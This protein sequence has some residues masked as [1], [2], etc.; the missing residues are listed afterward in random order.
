MPSTPDPQSELDILIRS[1][2]GVIVLDTADEARADALIRQA[3]SRL[4]L[5]M[6]RWTRHAGLERL[7]ASEPAREGTDIPLGA[8]RAVAS[9]AVEG[10]FVFPVLEPWLEEP[11]VASALRECALVLGQRRGAV[12]LQG[13]AVRLPPG[14]SRDAATLALPH[15]TQDEYRALLARLAADLQPKMELRPE[16]TSQLLQNLQGMTTTEARRILTRVMLE[17]G[18]LHAG[19]IDR[20]ARAKRESIMQESLLEY[21]TVDETLDDVAGLERLKAWLQKRQTLLREPERARSLGLPFPRGLLLLGV[22]GCGKS[23]SAKAIAR[24]WGL[25]LV[26]LDSAR[27]YNKYV[28]ETERNLHR[29]I[30]AAEQAAPVVLWIDEIE[31]A[32]ATDG[33]SNDG[34]LSLRLLGSFLSWLQEREPPVFVVATANDIQRLPAEL[35]RKG[36]FDEIFFIDLPTAEE[37][38]AILTLQ[39]AKR[40]Q[41]PAAFDLDRLTDATAGWTGAELEQV[42]VSGL[43]AV[44]EGQ[45]RLSTDLL[46]DEI[47]R[48]RPLAVTR[49]EMVEGLRHWARER[50]RPAS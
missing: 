37:R 26:R 25:P 5:R 4:S 39:L 35:L 15:P 44:L 11:G 13:E 7:G 38:R 12:L 3:A 31:K 46:L 32:F 17:D 48:T 33:N 27:L 49:S 9:M 14:L 2:Y 24:A 10:L 1:R 6:W 19:D 20:V 41:E 40:G 16:E 22:P 43:Y 18:R 8:L 50:A 30:R 45:P 29:A 42:I 21:Y 34:G 47:S 23:L 36:R 28:G